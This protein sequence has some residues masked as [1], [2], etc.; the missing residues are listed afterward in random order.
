[1]AI[2]TPFLKN[3]WEIPLWYCVGKEDWIPIGKFDWPESKL[4]H[5]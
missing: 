1:M 3:M 4:M 2:N 5:I